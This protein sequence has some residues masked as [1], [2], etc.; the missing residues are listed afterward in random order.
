[1]QKLSHIHNIPLLRKFY[2]SL[3]DLLR[4]LLGD[5]DLLGLCKSM[6]RLIGSIVLI[7]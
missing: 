4:L 3:V 2:L 6:Q 7:V 5:W 1:M